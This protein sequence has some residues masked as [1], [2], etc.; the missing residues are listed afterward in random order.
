M[1]RSLNAR[2]GH[3]ADWGFIL[4]TKPHL[5]FRGQNRKWRCR[6]RP[7]A[8]KSKFCLRGHRSLCKWDRYILCKQE[9]LDLGNLKN[10]NLKSTLFCRVLL[11]SV[12]TNIMQ[13]GNGWLELV[14]S[15]GSMFWFCLILLKMDDVWRKRN[16]I[17]KVCTMLSFRLCGDEMIPGSALS[18]N[19]DGRC[20]NM[21]CRSHNTVNGMGW[22]DDRRLVQGRQATVCL[23]A[24]K[25][26]CL[27]GRNQ[28]G[29]ATKL[30]KVQRW[31]N[32][33]YFKQS[34]SVLNE[35]VAQLTDEYSGI[36]LHLIPFDLHMHE[37]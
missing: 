19:V 26:A 33:G 31:W 34:C 15:I 10:S 28:D 8:K 29:T 4:G 32:Y 16:F 7:N 18:L 2:E 3:C 36:V 37:S 22:S 5:N 1:C 23:C 12:Q 13:M 14:R 17:H 25:C 35:F 27:T 6:Q 24:A 20:Q 11:Q 30:W 21:V 9:L